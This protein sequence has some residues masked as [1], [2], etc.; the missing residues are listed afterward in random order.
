MNKIVIILLLF[1]FIPA[2]QASYSYDGIPFTIASQGTLNGGVYI[3]GGHGL[4]FPPYSQ[5]FDVPDGHIRWSR[6]Y[7]GIWGGKEEYEGWIQVDMNGKSMDKVPLL[8]I[9]DDSTNVYCSGHG[10]YWVYYDVTD[11]TINGENTVIIE[12]SQGEPGNKLDGR[13]YGAV[14][15]AVYEDENAPEISYKIFDGNMNLHSGGWSGNQENINYE[16]SVFFNDMQ[17][18]NSLDGADITVV[19][20]TSSKGLPDYLQLNGHQLGTTPQYLQ[21]MGYQ[22]GVTDIANEVSGDACSGS[23][24]RSSYFDIECFDVLEYT[25]TDNVLTF[26]MG[27][28]LDGDGEIREDEGE[29]YLHPVITSLVLKHTTDTNPVP[30]LSIE[31]E[32]DENSLIEENDVEIPIVIGNPGGLHEGMFKIRLNVDG[33]EASTTEVYMDASGVIRSTINW[34]A[35]AGPHLLEIIVDPENAVQESDENNNIYE[36]E[37][38]VNTRPDLSISIGE[39]RKT[40]TENSL[41]KASS[42]LLMLL[43]IGSLRRRKAFLLAVLIVAACFSGCTGPGTEYQQ[44]DYQVPIVITNS[45]ESPARQFDVN[46]YL[47]EEKIAALHIQELEG[48]SSMEEEM[49]VTVEGGEHTLKAIV[50]EKNYIIESDEENNVDEIVYNFT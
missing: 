24:I 20:L 44:T 28:D 50:D 2:V 43:V 46:L 38:D 12:T 16:T 34:H 48:S 27:R 47:D 37:V 8:G 11:I 33:S 25:Q 14:L 42:P 31:V 4:E 10:V 6:L 7:V 32:M 35:T 13:V 19:Y 36:A 29:D 30:D 3:N 5:E 1:M 17:D 49:M 45:G 39:T 40:E 41:A 26:L 15:T 9:N 22:I 21:D 18:Q 23:G